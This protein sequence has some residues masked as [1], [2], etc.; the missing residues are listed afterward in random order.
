MEALKLTYSEQ[1]ILAEHPYT[2]KQFELERKLHGGFDSAGEYISPRTLHRV[3]AIQ[4]WRQQLTDRGK[5]IVDESSTILKGESYPNIAQQKHLIKHGFD[6]GLFDALTI[7]GITEARGEALVHLIAPDFQDIIVEDISQTALGHLN[8]GLLK[9]HGLD[10][11]GDKSNGEGGH[12]EMWFA[13]RDLIFHDKDYPLIQPGEG[14]FRE[15]AEREM[16]EIPLFHEQIIGMMLNVLL[17]E[18]RAEKF[19]SFCQDVFLD[20]DL[21]TDRRAHA[22]KA[23][24]LV[25]R[26]RVDEAS[27][28]A[29]L[30][31]VLSEFRS[32]TIKTEEGTEVSGSE[33]LDPHLKTMVEWHSEHLLELSKQNS[34]EKY[35]DWLLSHENGDAVYKT[36]LRLGF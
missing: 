30:E 34:A 23:A 5:S 20:E 2:Q 8:K 17:I 1:E 36:F 29:Y 14:V 25:E 24:E 32:F 16:P 4:N 7:T 18:Y 9:A 28:V 10:E 13:L 15:K 19:F 27:H 35:K 3:E 26:I 11:G 21:F 6:Q 12:D 33:I 22:K 31:T